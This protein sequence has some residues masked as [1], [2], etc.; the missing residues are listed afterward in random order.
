MYSYC[1][2]LDT[3]PTEIGKLVALKRLDV[4][5]NSLSKL[6][7]QLGECMELEDINLQRN[8]LVVLPNYFSTFSCLRTLNL[9]SN[10]L[11][12]F[13]DDFSGLKSLVQVYWI[14]NHVICQLDLSNC[15]LASLPLCV[16]TLSSLRDIRAVQNNFKSLPD[17]VS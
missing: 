2:K 5:R 15:E 3:L 1:S 13:P 11:R 10:P 17:Q 12:T 6:P 9:S 8:Y 7:D 16:C 14:M 4:K